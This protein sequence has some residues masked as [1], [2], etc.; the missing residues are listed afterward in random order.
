MTVIP[1]NGVTLRFLDRLFRA[2]NQAKDERTKRTTESVSNMKL[3]KVQGWEKQFAQD[4][5]EHRN[6]E[7]TRLV[8]R[9]RVRAFNTAVSN[10]VPVLVLV[11]TLTAYLRS[12]RPIVASTIFTAISLFNQLR[13]PLFFYPML[14]DSSAKAMDAIRRISSYLSSEEIVP[15]VESLPAVNGGGS[16]EMKNGN[17]LW[18]TSDTPKEGA[19]SRAVAPALCAANLKVGPGEIVAVVGPVGSGKTAL[20]K[21]LLGELS[22]VPRA[23]VDGSLTPG[24]H[25]TT[26]DALEKPTV[27]HEGNVAYCSQEAWLPKGTLRDAVVFGR[28]YNEERYKAAIYDSGLD[29]DIVD[30]L[31]PQNSKSAASSGVLSHDTDVGESG[32]S[33]SGGQRARV[34][35]AR[36]L[37][38]GDDTKIFLLDDCL[39]ALDAGVGSMVFERLSARLKKSN[40][41]ALFVTNDP[42][43]PRRCDQVVLMGSLDKKVS[44]TQSSCSSIVDCG[45]YDELISRGYNL[46][47][48]S[49][50]DDE[51]IMEF[52]EDHIDS[53]KDQ[54]HVVSAQ[55]GYAE[56]EIAELK[57]SNETVVSSQH[58]DPD[59]AE[60]DFQNNADLLAN[61]VF[62][63]DGDC[64]SENE[65]RCRPA[66][67]NS[68]LASSDTAI[69]GEGSASATATTKLAS[70]DENMSAQAVPIGTYISYLKSIRSPKLIIMTL[71]AFITVNTATFLNQYFVAKWTDLGAEAMASAVGNKYLMRLNYSAAVASIFLW[72]RSFLNTYTGAKASQFYHDRMLS[73]VFSAP[74]SFFDSTPSGQILSRFGKELGTID[75]DLPDTIASVL[76]CALQI[77]SSVVALA[78]AITPAMMVPILLVGRMYGKVMGKFRPAARDLKRSEVKTRSPIFT[79][80]GEALRGIE[81]KLCCW[82]GRSLFYSCQIS[83]H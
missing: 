60:V 12:G 6:D 26:G 5:S 39:A 35:L 40:S 34:A 47:S 10:A 23:I 67:D 1:L 75:R 83:V 13:F 29:K 28:E 52:T 73:S 15:Y 19:V 70:A 30:N 58:A 38:S 61:R 48:F 66:N 74:M 53:S 56:V 78:G 50:V 4:I 33:L 9:G 2:E 81:G 79:H 76:F 59:V 17:F 14:I 72:F 46:K 31:Q 69:N 22:P 3:L 20:I 25:E 18:P 64:D 51:E 71:A 68:T 37:Y 8:N 16:I 77:A 42:S 7:L 55:D 27:I 57:S 11:V 24:S 62:P 45:T 65:K 54:K 82:Y 41:A 32:S 36:A 21:A 44:P 80:F 63:V 49:A 43:L